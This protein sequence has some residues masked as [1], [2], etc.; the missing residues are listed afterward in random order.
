MADKVDWC[1]PWMG[2]CQN[3]EAIIQSHT[4]GSNTNTNI[5]RNAKRSHSKQELSH[6]LYLY[7]IYMSSRPRSCQLKS[8]LQEY[9]PYWIMDVL[10]EKLKGK[11]QNTMWQELQEFQTS[12]FLIMHGR[13]D[14]QSYT[15][16]HISHTIK[17]KYS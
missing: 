16:G 14:I 4:M 12:Q 5:F 1:V 9:L 2:G 10:K 8:R 15:I 7:G 6:K 13:Y 3:W 11:K 17:K